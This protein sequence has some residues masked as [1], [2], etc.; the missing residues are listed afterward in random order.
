MGETKRHDGFS[1]PWKGVRAGFSR[2]G[3]RRRRR[4]GVTGNDRAGQMVFA[5]DWGK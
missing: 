5:P 2:W 3:K 1:T 4:K